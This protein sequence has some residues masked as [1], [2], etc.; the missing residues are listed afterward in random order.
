ME[1]GLLNPHVIKI[2]TSA[3][4]EDTIIGISKR[5]NLSYGWTNK[6]VN[7]LI[8]EGVFKE[9]WRGI[10]LQEDNK[11]YQKILKFIKDIKDVRFYYSVLNLFGIEYCFTKTDAVYVWTEGRY[12]IARYKRFY[13][14]FIKINESD[15]P[16]F[17]EYCRK[18]GLS[19]NSKEGI[20]Y[21]PEVLKRVKAVK[22]HGF[23]VEPLD[24]TIK[25]MQKNIYNFQPA[26]EMI[27][28]TSGRKLGIKY[29]EAS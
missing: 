9:K 1:I 26:L 13:P 12:N 18:L 5:I 24:E 17:L 27:Q 11:T 20:F 14:I 7:E 21:S 25:F 29:R 15:Y 19:I 10:I 3:R 6:W 4:K 23:F 8:K 2:L 22:R 16:I 28:E